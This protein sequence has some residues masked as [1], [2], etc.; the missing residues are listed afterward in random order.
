MASTPRAAGDQLRL[1]AAHRVVKQR[2][3]AAGVPP[4]T[5][6]GSEMIVVLDTNHFTDFANA[7]APG[8]RLMARMD[9]RNSD[10]FTCIVAAEESLQGWIAFTRR[11]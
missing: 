5:P 1:G 4:R 3:L 10:S 9:E 7:S 8:H 6:A 2:A 11:R